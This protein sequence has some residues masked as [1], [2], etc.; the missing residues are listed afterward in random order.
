MILNK[1]VCVSDRMPKIGAGNKAVFYGD[2]SGLYINIREQISTQVLR[3][4]YATMHAIGVNMWFEIDS[5]LA[6]LQKIAALQCATA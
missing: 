4:K 5:K 3:E 1:E 6:E 2:P